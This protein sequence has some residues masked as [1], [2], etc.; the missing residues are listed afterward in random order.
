MHLKNHFMH[1]VPLKIK[2]IK[3]LKYLLLSCNAMLAMK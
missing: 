2:F 3:Y 1:K